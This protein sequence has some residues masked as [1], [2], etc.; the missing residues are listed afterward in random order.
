MEKQITFVRAGHNEP[1]LYTQEDRSAHLIYSD[2]ALLCSAKAPTLEEVR[3]DLSP[4]SV[5]L[6]YTD[7][8]TEA[9]NAEKEEFGT[10]RLQ[11]SLIEYAELPA[12]SIV[13]NIYRDVTR[14]ANHKLADDFTVIA[15]KCLE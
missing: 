13:E 8:V 9:S 7:G 2:G 5:F 14:F 15:L 6:Q 1:L 12:Q 10:G 11:K 3:L 4:G